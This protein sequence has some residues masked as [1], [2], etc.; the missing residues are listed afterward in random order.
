MGKGTGLMDELWRI[1]GD[2]GLVPKPG[3]GN[4]NGEGRVQRA[5]WTSGTGTG[6][7]RCHPGAGG[8]QR[9]WVSTRCSSGRV[10]QT[11]G[12]ESGHCGELEFGDVRCCG[13]LVWGLHL[14][15]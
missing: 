12:E 8:P 9:A 1:K 2:V 10:W 6:W 3:M 11:A 15:G 13:C 14:P 4:R 5:S 7:S